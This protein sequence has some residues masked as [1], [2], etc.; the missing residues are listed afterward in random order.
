MVNGQRPVGGPADIQLDPVGPEPEGPE[1]RLQRVLTDAT[2]LVRTASMG[3]DRRDR[4][5][6]GTSSDRSPP[7]AHSGRIPGLGGHRN[8][9][10]RRVPVITLVTET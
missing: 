8:L 7:G 2:G 6:S 10:H 9:L 5:R 3:L 1:E 4:H